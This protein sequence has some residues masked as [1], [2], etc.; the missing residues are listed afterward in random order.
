[1]YRLLHKGLHEIFFILFFDGSMKDRVLY[2]HTIKLFIYSIKNLFPVIVK[3]G[4]E[5]KHV[6]SINYVRWEGVPVIYD[7]VLVT[8]KSNIS[9]DMFLAYLQSI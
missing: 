1:M 6:Q 9:V 7:S 2:N 5:G 8:L 3:E 4:L